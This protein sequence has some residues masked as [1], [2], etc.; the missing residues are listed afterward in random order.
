MEELRTLLALSACCLAD[1]GNIGAYK[2]SLA[3]NALQSEIWSV[4][5][6][7]VMRRYEDLEN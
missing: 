3:G 5:L 6:S 7:E 2:T 1:E 4:V